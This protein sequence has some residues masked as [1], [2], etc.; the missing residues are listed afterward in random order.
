M[1]Y[2]HVFV[3]NSNN[4]TIR[5]SKVIPHNANDQVV[6]TISTMPT[7]NPPPVPVS[8]KRRRSTD[9]VLSNTTQRGI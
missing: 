3:Q 5:F 9:N 1:K 8:R 2:G 6:P 4:H 7:L